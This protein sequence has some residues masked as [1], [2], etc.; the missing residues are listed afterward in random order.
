MKQIILFPTNFPREL[1]S[2]SSSFGSF[3]FPILLN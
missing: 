3:E 2:L 1:T